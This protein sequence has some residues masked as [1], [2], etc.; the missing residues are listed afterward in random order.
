MVQSVT[1]NVFHMNYWGLQCA[2]FALQII[3][4][5]ILLKQQAGESQVHGQCK[6]N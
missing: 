3:A 1:I 6:S 4:S 5:D 2:I